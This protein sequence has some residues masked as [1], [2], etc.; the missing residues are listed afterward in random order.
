VKV[1]ACAKVTA[2]GTSSFEAGAPP[3]KS[4]L[5]DATL[6]SGS[7][8]C[9]SKDTLPPA[10]IVT[11]PGGE[12]IVPSGGR[13]AAGGPRTVTWRVAGVGSEAPSSSVTTSSTT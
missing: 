12:T 4:Q 9:P 2:P 8:A 6:P 10:G 5:T 11:S 3:P 13:F 1:P 7:L